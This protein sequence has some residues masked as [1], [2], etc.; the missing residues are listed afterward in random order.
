MT[1][2]RTAVA[3]ALSSLE[4]RQGWGV[5]ATGLAVLC[6]VLSGFNRNIFFGLTPGLAL[7]LVLLPLWASQLRSSRWVAWTTVLAVVSVAWGAW[8]TI[9]HA[10]TRGVSTA[11]TLEASFVVLALA[12]GVG[13]ALWA[14]SRTSNAV[15]GAAFGVGLVLGINPASE[16]FAE[17]PWRFGFSLP[18]T[19]LVLAI[20]SRFRRRWLDVVAALALAGVSALNGGRSS[21]A[22]LL[23]VA[24]LVVWQSWGRPA[25]SRLAALRTLLL[26]GLLALGTYLSVQAAILEGAL[27][28]S[29]QMRTELQL[30]TSGTLI[31]G[32]RPEIGATLAL[33]AE[34]PAGF[35]GG[36][37]PSMADLLVAKSGMAALGYDPNNGYVENYM[38]GSGFELHS[39]IGDLW[40]WCG[41]PGLVLSVV[42]LV[43]LVVRTAV[44]TTGRAASA[45]ILFLGVKSVWNLLFAPLE[46]ALTVLVLAVALMAPVLGAAGRADQ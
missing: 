36:S 42:L 3:P 29:A 33:M 31:T 17:N 40:A 20:V 26:F 22:I 37:I 43:F 28:E 44:L 8:L 18:V 12:C 23:M 19:V 9:W 30:S 14:R 5:A 4:G 1:S 16:T 32:G 2:P 45:L 10:D 15:V 35:G 38:F 7:A 41:I 27:G 13:A 11:G 25:S 46:S 6:M 24:L 21:S 39:V 34:A